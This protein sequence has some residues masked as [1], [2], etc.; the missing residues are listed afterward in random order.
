MAIVTS[1]VRS[2]ALIV[3]TSPFKLQLKSVGV[4]IGSCNHQ[5]DKRTLRMG[6]TLFFLFLYYQY[7]QIKKKTPPPVGESY[8]GQV[9]SLISCAL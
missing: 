2:F 1:Y 7:R 6:Q 8:T 3:A 5:E 9:D 4:V